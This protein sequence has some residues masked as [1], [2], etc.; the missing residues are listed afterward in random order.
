MRHLRFGVLLYCEDRT[1]PGFTL[2][3]PLHGSSTYLINPHGDV[4]HQWDHPLINSSYAQL[5]QN[6]NL[7]WAGR[8]PEGQHHMGGRGGLLREYDWCGIVT[9][10]NITIS[11]ACPTAIHCS[12]AGRS[13]RP[14]LRAGCRA[15][16]LAR[17]TPIAACTATVRNQ[18]GRR[19]RLGV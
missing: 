2:Y 8:L 10:G 18:F 4:V 16:F 5:L 13:S 12:S 14:T 7:L 6:G 9:S 3:S 17:G 1:E 15:A 19:G 11:G